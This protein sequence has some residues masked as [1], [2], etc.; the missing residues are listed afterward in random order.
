MSRSDGIPDLEA[1]VAAVFAAVFPDADITRESDFF[2]LG[3][4]S[5]AAL[6]IVLHLEERLG[7]PVHPAALLHHPV[8]GD[9]ASFLMAEADS[10][11][12]K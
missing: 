2:D 9:L 6:E 3:G 11:S 4:D 12:S 7:R 1:V 8:V 10:T 5:G